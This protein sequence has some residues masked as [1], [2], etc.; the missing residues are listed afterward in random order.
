MILDSADQFLQSRYTQGMQFLF[1]SVGPGFIGVVV[2]HQQFKFTL[3][4]LAFI[5]T[6]HVCSSDLITA[7]TP[8]LL[9]HMENVLP[10]LELRRVPV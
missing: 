8:Y 3:S 5:W 1:G 10:T 7:Y 9:A 4:L 2:G 6:T